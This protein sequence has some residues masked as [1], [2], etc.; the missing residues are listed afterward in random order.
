MKI[1]DDN[2]MSLTLMRDL[3]SQNRTNHI[4]VIHQHV[5]QLV[6]NGELAI[7]WISSLN[8]LVDGL[9]KALLTRPFKKHGEE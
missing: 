1:L 6:E 8:I 9:T 2:K 7:K 3:E 5:L 4:V